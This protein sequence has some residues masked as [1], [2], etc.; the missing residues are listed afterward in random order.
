MILLKCFQMQM[1]ETQLKQGAL[2][3]KT[4]KFSSVSH[5]QH[6]WFEGLKL[7]YY[8]SSPFNPAFFPDEFLPSAFSLRCH[9]GVQHYIL[10]SPWLAQ[11]EIHFL[12]VQVKLLD[13]D[14]AD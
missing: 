1:K 12:M 6:G 11:R 3:P 8:L 10:I 14:I 4:E 13:L 7:Y 5:L 2:V 9:S